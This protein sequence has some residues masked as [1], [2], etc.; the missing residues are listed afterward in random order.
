VEAA[1]LAPL[2]IGGCATARQLI[3]PCGLE[4]ID[5]FGDRLRLRQ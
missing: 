3:K 2:V 4:G 1:L 5:M